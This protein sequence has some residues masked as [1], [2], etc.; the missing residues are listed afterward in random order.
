MDD[1]DKR[2]SGAAEQTPPKTKAE[3]NPW[4]LLAALW[5]ARVTR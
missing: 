4:Y 1:A 3:D 5:R 2:E